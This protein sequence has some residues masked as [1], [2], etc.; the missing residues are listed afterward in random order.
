MEGIAMSQLT[1]KDIARK[2]GVSTATVSRVINGIGNVNE[3]MKLRVQEVIAESGFK[4]NF[5]ARSLKVNKTFTIG[6]IVSD[7]SDRYYSLMA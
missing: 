4:P 2:A 5:S 7:I 1:I 3:E 6:L